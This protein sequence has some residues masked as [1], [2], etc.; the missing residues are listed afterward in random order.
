MHEDPELAQARNFLVELRGH[1]QTL[2][3]RRELASAGAAASATP[4]DAELT[5]VRQQID[6]IL[7]RF[8]ALRPPTPR[9]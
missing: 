2:M 4:F 8:P 3:R 1:A 5:A 7:N 9:T 6:K